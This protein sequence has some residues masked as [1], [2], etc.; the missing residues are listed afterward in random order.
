MRRSVTIATLFAAG[1]AVDQHARSENS[2]IQKI[3]QMLNDMSAKAKQE[4]RDEEVEF[5]KFSQFCAGGKPALKKRIA[6]STETIETLTAEIGVL[7]SQAKTLGENVAKLQTDVTN[8][9]ADKKA[10]IAQREK[11]HAEFLKESKDYEE[12]LDA[13]DRAILVLMKKS[14]DVP[15]AAML[16]VT[17]D[18]RLP[19]QARTVI[20]EFLGMDS[21]ADY[22]PPEAKAYESQSGGV[23]DML[24]KLKDDF[25][26]KL[27]QCQ[28]EEMNSKNAHDMIVQD[29]V[30]SIENAQR[31]AEEQTAEKEAKIEKRAA[32][33]RE[34]QSTEVVKDEDVKTYANLDVEC[35]EKKLSFEEK[36]QLRTDEIAALAKAM[37][38][39]QGD[40]VSGNAEKHL[41]LLHKVSFAQL[42][43]VTH[44]VSDTKA[45]AKVEGIHRR[46]REFLAAEG[47]RLNS[48]NLGLLAENIA[49]DPFSKVRKMIDDMI[50][51]LLNEANADATKEGWC[52]TEMGK[53]KT[54]RNKLSE[55]IDGL[56]SAI[57][58]G[59]ATVMKLTQEMADL[60]KDLDEIEVDVGEASDLRDAEKAKNKITIA[61][62]S[63]AQKAIAA[64]TAV[65]KDFYAK[66]AGATAFVQTKPSSLLAKGIHMGSDEWKSLA[67]P[68]F[69]GTVDKGHKEGM[70]T[71]GEEFTG[72]QDAAG[73]VLALLEVAQ[74]DFANLEAD[75]KAAETESQRAYDSYRTEA[76]KNKAVKSRKVDMDQ[77]DKAAA[78]SKLQDDIAELK[79]TQDELIA[80]EKYHERLVPQCNDQGMSWEEVQAA[81]RAEIT[82]LKEALEILNGQG[83]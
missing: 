8:F 48:K 16:Q 79:A 68:N 19:V 4:K 15:G 1:H 40:A 37:E 30:G 6:K 28:K 61:D 27:S 69:E 74:S 45:D 57:E 23:I 76:K 70:Q 13:I 52:D 50:T 3:I 81:R 26:D 55:E 60:S 47:K 71:F 21:D 64:A 25:R 18:A 29:L 36:Q 12:S 14:G 33:T 10:S 46:I 32:N 24:K 65:L 35:E 58:D 51:R 42:R 59:K 17:S 49:S 82:S 54:T 38:I 22:E 66:A 43:S 73:G 9:E 2:A 56:Q 41:S 78:E 44:S 72:Q 5:A 53:S 11:D 77:S 20:S 75:T 34:L 7:G 62:A 80:A 31:T 83:M 67:N 39:L 63:A